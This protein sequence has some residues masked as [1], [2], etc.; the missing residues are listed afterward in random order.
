MPPGGVVNHHVDIGEELFRPIKQFRNFY[1]IFRSAVYNQLRIDGELPNG[2]RNGGAVV[3]FPQ[4]I[5][6]PLHA[7]APVHLM[8]KC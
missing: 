5:E 8:L 7:R 3:P 1:H 4:H 2:I 6:I